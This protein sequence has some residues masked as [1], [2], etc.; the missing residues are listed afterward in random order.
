MKPTALWLAKAT[1]AACFVLPAVAATTA[2]PSA[3]TAATDTTSDAPT[4]QARSA[5]VQRCVRNGTA[6]A[7]NAPAAAR[8]PQTR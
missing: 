4:R 2:P 6:A 5:F 7:C 3:P 8:L 1:L